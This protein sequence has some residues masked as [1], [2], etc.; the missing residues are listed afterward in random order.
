MIGS[1]YNNRGAEKPAVHRE[2]ILLHNLDAV[3]LVFLR[4]IPFACLDLCGLF[5][6]SIVID[7]LVL[8]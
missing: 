8:T 1:T 4:P 7:F 3:L 2:G 6:L 5:A